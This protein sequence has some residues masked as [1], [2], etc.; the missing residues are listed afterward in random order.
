MTRKVD[1]KRFKKVFTTPAV[2]A[3]WDVKKTTEQNFAEMGLATHLNKGRDIARH[4]AV[5][6][7]SDE[8]GAEGVTLVD[9][10]EVKEMVCV[11]SS[12][13]ERR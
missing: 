3:A 5:R 1:T 10:E 8:G 4:A 6:L 12:H 2:R 13:V 9:L 7:L 11:C